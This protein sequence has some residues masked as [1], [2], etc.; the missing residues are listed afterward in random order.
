MKVDGTTGGHVHFGHPKIKGGRTKESRI[1][2]YGQ[3]AILN[4]NLNYLLSIPLMFLENSHEA[5]HRKGDRG[6]GNFSDYR[7][8]VWGMEYRT[9]GSWL[10]S[11]KLATG[12]ICLAYA[13]GSATLD[14]GYLL[15]YLK[16]FSPNS[17]LDINSDFRGHDVRNFHKYLKPLF[18]EIV[19]LPYYLKYKKEINPLFDAIKKK[20]KLFDTEIKWG[21]RINFKGIDN[22]NLLPLDKTTYKL[23]TTLI[24][25]LP[26]NIS[27]F[28]LFDSNQYDYRIQELFEKLCFAF[29]KT[30]NK[31]QL[32]GAEGVR[33]YGIKEK[34]GNTSIIS[35][36]LSASDRE[37]LVRIIDKLRPL[38]PKNSRIQVHASDTD[39]IGFSREMRRKNLLACS[40]V[41]IALALLINPSLYRYSLVDKKTGRI[42]KTKSSYLQLAEPLLKV[43]RGRKEPFEP[44]PTADSGE[45]RQ[46]KIDTEVIRRL[47]TAPLTR[48]RRLS[49]INLVKIIGELERLTRATNHERTSSASLDQIRAWRS[50]MKR[51]EIADLRKALDRSV[52]SKRKEETKHFEE[53][54]P[55]QLAGN[56]RELD[57]FISYYFSQAYNHF[58]RL[59]N[60]PNREG[61]GIGGHRMYSPRLMEEA[62]RLVDEA[63]DEDEGLVPD[64]QRD[65]QRDIQ[66]ASERLTSED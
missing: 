53:L 10:A 4:F 9:P 19:Q 16:I 7:P 36:T 26:Q 62:E 12:T 28:D 42:K 41:T 55:A 56:L 32:E 31:K 64:F 15:P 54:T 45:N 46:F 47:N 29:G 11:E 38:F 30:F 59:F 20:Q 52:G 17:P 21:W 24:V 43:L 60:E 3:Q 35:T 63:D 2:A 5:R 25:P 49:R 23:A 39:T 40:A 48:G 51:P 18:N 1:N 44:L 65:F 50:W 34:R 6:Y 66:R 22:F 61:Q 13:L 27:L 57:H 37:R 33:L 58:R 14:N 8:Q